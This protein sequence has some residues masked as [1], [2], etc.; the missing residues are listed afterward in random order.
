MADGEQVAKLRQGVAAWNT[1]RRDNPTIRPDLSGITLEGTDFSGVNLSGANL[2][3]ANLNRI[4]FIRASLSG[5]N[6]SGASLIDATLVDANLSGANLS[7]AKLPEATL[8]RANLSGADLSHVLRW[9]PAQL[10]AAYWDKQT[11]W[12]EGYHPPT[13]Q[14]LS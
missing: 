12:P 3:G 11:R 8:I 1:W 13:P 5:A 2:G 6:L 10:S 7:G 4:Y 14:R 9:K